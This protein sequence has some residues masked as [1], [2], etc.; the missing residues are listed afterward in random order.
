M[1]MLHVCCNNKKKIG[2]VPGIPGMKPGSNR[3][4][5]GS[6][7]SFEPYSD[8]FAQAVVAFLIRNTTFRNL[9]FMNGSKFEPCSNHFG[10]VATWLRF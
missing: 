8:H 10:R 9:V 6:F 4:E 2:V 3:N 1:L 7:G 5:I